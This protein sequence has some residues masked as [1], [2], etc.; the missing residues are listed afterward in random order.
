[1]LLLALEAAPVIP[2]SPAGAQELSATSSRD[3]VMIGFGAQ[4]CATY[5]TGLQNDPNGPL[6]AGAPVT[7]WIEGFIS[8]LDYLHRPVPEHTRIDIGGVALWIKEFCKSSP[9]RS[10]ADAVLAF[11]GTGSAGETGPTGH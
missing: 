8:A 1:M 7:Q 5:L 11:E 3:W 9:Q 10:V 2:M 4:S 6:T